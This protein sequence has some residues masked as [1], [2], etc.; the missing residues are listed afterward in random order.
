VSSH[1][2]IP[3]FHLFFVLSTCY[4]FSLPFLDSVFLIIHF[5]FI[6]AYLCMLLCL[7]SAWSVGYNVHHKLIV[8]LQITLNHLTYSLGMLQLF[9]SIHSRSYATYCFPFLPINYYERNLKYGGN[10][11]YSLPLLACF[12]PVWNWI[13]ICCHFPAVLGSSF[14]PSHSADVLPMISLSFVFIKWKWLWR[15]MRML[16]LCSNNLVCIINFNICF[17]LGS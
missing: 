14:N 8:Y 17:R 4:I 15:K 11:F 3:S 2:N 16:K 5:I 6:L 9:I 7:F 10:I 12:V 1:L 13:A